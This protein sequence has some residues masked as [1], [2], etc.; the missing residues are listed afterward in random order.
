MRGNRSELDTAAL[1]WLSNE[2]LSWFARQGSGCHLQGAHDHTRYIYQGKRRRGR[3]AET[4]ASAY[5]SYVHARHNP[6]SSP[7][8]VVSAAAHQRAEPRIGLTTA[9]WRQQFHVNGGI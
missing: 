5:T 8:A 9:E 4:E 6:R 2:T 1:E 3:R 7:F